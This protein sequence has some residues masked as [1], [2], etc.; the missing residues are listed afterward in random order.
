MN[1]VK[2]SILIGFS[3]SLLCIVGFSSV[4]PKIN[5]LWVENQ[6]WNGLSSFYSIELPVRIDSLTELEITVNPSGSTLFIIGPYQGFTMVDAES[7]LNYLGRGGTLVLLDDFGSG[8]QLLSLL[9]LDVRFDS[10]VMIDPIFRDR[11]MVLPRAITI[12]YPTVEYIVLNYPTTLTNVDTEYVTVWS[13]PVSYLL[14]EMDEEPNGYSSN[15]VV[16]EIPFDNGKIVLISDSS[17]FIN[18]MIEK[19]DNLELLEYLSKGSS[20]IDESHI[21]ETRLSLFQSVLANIYRVTGVYEIRYIMTFSVILL[22]FSLNLGVQE[23]RLDP[24]EEV[25]S[26]HPEYD[27]KTVEWLDREREKIHE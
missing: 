24:V 11:N 21:L 2:L 4:Y 26:L 6:F 20:M 13:S 1:K 8:N 10:R 19:G 16:A 17:I 25:M 15:P 27:R 14:S 23:Q 9:G 12:A 5:D 7:I 3:F 22:I 18:G